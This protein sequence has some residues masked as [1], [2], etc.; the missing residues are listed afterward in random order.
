MQL[1]SEESFLSQK[2]KQQQQQQ[3]T[4]A[5]QQAEYMQVMEL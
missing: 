5:P 2:Q 3:P 4:Q 1:G